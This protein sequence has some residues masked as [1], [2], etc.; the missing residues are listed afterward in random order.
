MRWI[1]ALSGLKSGSLFSFLEHLLGAVAI[2]PGRHVQASADFE[3]NEAR[4]ALDAIQAV[5]RRLYPS[6]SPQP[7]SGVETPACLLTSEFC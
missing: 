4:S 5:R 3:R 2:R 6:R 1:A 7:Y